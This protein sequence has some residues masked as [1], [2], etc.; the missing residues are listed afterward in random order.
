MLENLNIR[1]CAPISE[2]DVKLIPGEDTCLRKAVRAVL[3]GNLQ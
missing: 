3:P 2:Q 1:V